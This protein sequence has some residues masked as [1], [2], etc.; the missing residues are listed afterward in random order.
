MSRSTSVSLLVASLLLACATPPPEEVRAWLRQ[1]AVP[2]KAKERRESRQIGS[3]YREGLE[4]VP[5]RMAELFDGILFVE[6]TRAAIA[7]PSSKPPPAVK[8][9][10]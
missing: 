7:N 8:G 5:L 2:L 6:K 3:H 9:T 10:P 4:L 1:A